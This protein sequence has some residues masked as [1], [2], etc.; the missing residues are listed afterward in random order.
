MAD[1]IVVTVI[2]EDKTG[3]VASVSK[4]LSESRLNIVDITQKVFENNIFA[5][6]MLVKTEE[7]SDIRK[8]QEDFKILEENLGVKI[9]LQHE[10]IFKTMHRI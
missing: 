9:F 2:G 7:Y 10:E 4:K 5:M 6:V 3:I 8:L 1:R